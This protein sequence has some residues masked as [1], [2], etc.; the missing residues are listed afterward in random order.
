MIALITALFISLAI[1]LVVSGDM[2]WLAGVGFN[3]MSM[4]QAKRVIINEILFVTAV[5]MALVINLII[6]YSKN[7]GLLFKNETSVLDSVSNGDLSQLVPVA[8]NDEFG[9]IAG[10]TND[11]IIGLRHRLQLMTS[12]KLAEEV[13][14]NL[15]PKSTPKINGLDIAG[16]IIYCG[17]TGGD[18]FDYLPAKNNNHGRIDIVVGDVSPGM[19]LNPPYL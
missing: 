4:S 12:L 13:G 3:E 18:Y 14:Q 17:E 16:K 5:V 11:M 7:L 1:V 9:V 10:H 6:S 8:T 19:V 2:V 15:I